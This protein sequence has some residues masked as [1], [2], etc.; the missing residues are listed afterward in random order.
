MGINPNSMSQIANEA[1]FKCINELMDKNEVICANV[2]AV[3]A[4]DSEPAIVKDEKVDFDKMGV[5]ALKKYITDN[6]GT[7]HHMAGQQKLIE[8]AKELS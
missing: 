6:G 8:T 4:Q 5:D 7:F 3:A 2:E 1:L